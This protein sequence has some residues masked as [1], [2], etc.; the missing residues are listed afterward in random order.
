MMKSAF[1][2]FVMLLGVAL[3]FPGAAYAGLEVSKKITGIDASNDGIA[4]ITDAGQI[5]AFLAAV[6]ALTA[7]GFHTELTVC[8]I[9]GQTVNN[10]VVT[11]N[12]GA[13]LNVVLD[14]LNPIQGTVLF[15]GGRSAKNSLSWSVG[16]LA[17][18][19]CATLKFVATT[20]L[21]P[22]GVQTY[23]SCG[24]HEFNSGPVAKGRDAATNKQVT[25]GGD[26]ILLYV[27]PASFPNPLPQCSNCADDD[28]DQLIDF[29][30]D[31]G[32]ADEADND[33]IDPV[34]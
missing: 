8:A 24:E 29:P 32:C 5:Q 7:I 16:T 14:P 31:P 9:D 4:E 17:A 15:K 1:L 11:D 33:E 25:D 18:P 30:A 6:P 10:V 23:T 28:G 12:F 13:E 34:L 3:L 26:Q 19:S 21:D 2:T 22:S 20:K 27:D